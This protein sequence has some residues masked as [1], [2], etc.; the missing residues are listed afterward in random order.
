MAAVFVSYSKHDV[1][2]ARRVAE[3][4][5]KAGVDVWWDAHLAAG[6]TFRK[7]IGDELKKAK[8]VVV[9]WS[10]HSVNSHFVIDEA[11]EGKRRGI[12]IQGILD[13]AEPPLGFRQI[14]WA[15]LRG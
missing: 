3:A 5:Q 10:A 13:H 12:L 14:Q 8:C 4:L 2:Q 6:S 9:L 1:D 15:N 7:E 11:E